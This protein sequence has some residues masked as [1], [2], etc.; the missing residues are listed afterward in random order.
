MGDG[1][2]AAG[3]VEFVQQGSHMEL[4][5][6]YRYAKVTRYGLVRGTLHKQPKNLEFPRR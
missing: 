3:R 6:V 2:R 4:G 1:I 5:R